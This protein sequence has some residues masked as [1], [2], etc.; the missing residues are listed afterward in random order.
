MAT[1]KPKAGPKVGRTPLGTVCDRAARTVAAEAVGMADSLARRGTDAWETGKARL[2]QVHNWVRQLG[3]AG[4]ELS[5]QI[6]TVSDS[7]ARLSGHY[8]ADLDKL[9]RIKASDR[10]N[11]MLALNGRFPRENLTPDAR[12]ALEIMDGTF[13]RILRAAQLLDVRRDVNGRRMPIRGSGKPYPQILSRHGERI[14]EA[15]RAERMTSDALMASIRVLER[16][17]EVIRPLVRKL[18]PGEVRDAR[19]VALGHTPPD[20][21]A[22][23]IE[24]GQLLADNIEWGFA[25]LTEFHDNAVRGIN[26]YLER[27]RIELPEEMIEWDPVKA[28]P[29]FFRQQGLFLAAVRQWGQD[30][31]GAKAAIGHI[32]AE[33]GPQQ[34]D[35]IHNYIGLH[36]GKP[37]AG[38]PA[39]KRILQDIRD[40]T[41]LRI[42]GGTILGPMRNAGQ[43]F[44]NIADLP[45]SAWLRSMK[46]LPPFV[47]RW[48]DSAEK[49]RGEIIRSGAI[50]SESALTEFGRGRL[51]RAARGAATVHRMVVEENEFRAAMIGALGVEENLRRLIDM[52][53]ERGELAQAMMKL[54][55][56]STDPEAAIMRSLERRGIKASSIERIRRAAREASPEELARLIEKPSRALSQDE[57]LTAIM[58]TSHDTQF[59]Y[60]FASKHVFSGQDDAYGLLY[61][62]KNWGVR[63]LGFL[64]EH[65][66][67]ELAQ[68]NAKPLVKVLATTF[69]LGEMYNQARDFLTGSERSLGRRVAAGDADMQT[70]ALTTLRNIGDGGGMGMLMDVMFGWNSLVFGPIE[71]TVRDMVRAGVQ[72]AQ[73]PTP[74][75]TARATREFLDRQF[76]VTN[77][78]RGLWNRTLA[79]N[80]AKHAR[81]FDHAKWQDR[82][83]R[84]KQGVDE[85]T[86]GAKIQGRAVDFLLGGFRFA[87]TERSLGYNAAANAIRAGN[88]DGA[89]E[90]MARIL[91]SAETAKERRE[92][93]RAMRQVGTRR[94]PLGPVP[95]RERA[96]FLRTLSP[97]DRREALRVQREWERE[98]ARA[99]GRA[100][101]MAARGS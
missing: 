51:G 85:P 41:M 9:R 94:S 87:P 72:V 75:Q 8:L 15:V 19:Q 21:S 48:L 38:L 81:Y 45:A 64:H 34:A 49:L 44:T 29:G 91:S 95:K 62:L 90:H 60:T 58:R 16:N 43:P 36:L 25:R 28:L 31:E 20:A 42:F 82:A 57:W 11:A 37:V 53:G 97:E 79:A 40:L 18:S 3:P 12:R 99:L 56:L 55:H 33:N 63:Q 22:R 5:R 23:A 101:R 4:E 52:Q 24:V 65:V 26:T 100:Q 47:H 54:R 59:G 39:Q 96:A 14:M 70:I 77:Q 80:E 35:L 32:R 67:K 30:M 66:L 1:T 84:W 78:A 83:R 69:V 88:I 2:L 6:K 71:G 17:H 92:R 73:D 68:G 50:T 10:K 93:I 61:M 98:W 7:A 27:T 89:A 74:G 46:A 76:V 13:G 86:I